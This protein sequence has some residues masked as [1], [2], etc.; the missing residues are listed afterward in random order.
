MKNPCFLPALFVLALFWTGCHQTS[1]NKTTAEGGTK[2][3]A[4][5]LAPSAANLPD[6]KLAGFQYPQDSTTLRRWIANGQQDSISLHGWGLWTALTSRIN[7]STYVY[8][9]WLT[10]QDVKTLTQTEPTAQL[11]MGA[12]RQGRHGKLAVPRQFLR[13]PRLIQ[14]LAASPTSN[15]DKAVMEIVSYSPATANTLVKNRLFVDSTLQGRLSRGQLGLSDFQNFGLAIKPMVQIVPGPTAPGKAAPYLLKV[16][17]GPGTPAINASFPPSQ[18]PTYVLIDV[19]NRGKG[20][21][22]SQPVNQPVKDSLAIT[23]N[24]NDFVH[25]RLTQAEADSLNSDGDGGQHPTAHKGDYAVVVG[26]HVTTSEINN[27]T[28]QTFWWVPNPDQAYLPTSA[29]VVAARPAQLTGAPRH[30]AM[31]IGY[32][33]LTPEQPYEGGQ[34]VGQSAYVYNPYLEAPFGSDVFNPK[35]V[36]T[37]KTNNILITNNVGVRTNCMSCHL[38]AT[39]APAGVPTPGYIGDTYVARG[40][41]RF[42]NNLRTAF[43]WS[44]PDMA[45]PLANQTLKQAAARLKP[46]Q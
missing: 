45:S 20:A 42:R 40:M 18:W 39:Y 30:Y 31:S 41:P 2:E 22:Q 46:K 4:S 21:G 12:R 9:T 43:L 34:S 3:E 35:F 8:E 33:M 27:W 36:A 6:I 14:R 7:D 13:D 28:W 32:Q 29:A 26:M 37:V 10:K 17:S 44:I 24:V 23:Y 16:W 25:Y 15:P 11:A 5:A 19:L 1:D 38:Q